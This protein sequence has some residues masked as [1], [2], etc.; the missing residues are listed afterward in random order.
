MWE[1][2]DVTRERHLLG[3]VPSDT[4]AGRCKRKEKNSFG[5]KQENQKN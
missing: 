4:D 3:T 1:A 2:T 5:K